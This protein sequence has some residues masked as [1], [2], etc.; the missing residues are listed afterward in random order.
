M[1]GVATVLGWLLKTDGRALRCEVPDMSDTVVEGL[2]SDLLAYTS[3]APG[4]D[5]W[6]DLTAVDEP[7]NAAAIGFIDQMQDRTVATLPR[8]HGDAFIASHDMLNQPT[9][10]G[11]EGWH[12]LLQVFPGIGKD[13]SPEWE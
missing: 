2:G 11:P 13:F 4:V 9:G 8:I 10:I 5:V 3:I 7:L 1:E 6:R 12:S